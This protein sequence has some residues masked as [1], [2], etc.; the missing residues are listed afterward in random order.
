MTIGSHQTFAMTFRPSRTKQRE[1]L[2]QSE[3][4]KSRAAGLGEYPICRLCNLPINPGDTWHENHEAHKPRWLGGK[5]DGISHGSC[6]RRWNN[7]HDSPLYAK[8]ERQRKGFLDL[9]RS[10]TP[11]PGGR[12]DRIKKTMSGKVVDRS[13]GQPWGSR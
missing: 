12:E 11:L 2:Y 8:S 13:T 3:C 7:I 10:S 5:V 9:K 4:E 1:A 6:N